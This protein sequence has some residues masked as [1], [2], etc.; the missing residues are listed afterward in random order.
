MCKLYVFNLS[1]QCL[2]LHLLLL[3]CALIVFKLL[4]V[5]THFILDFIEF[6]H[7]T[8]DF[9]G[10]ILHVLARLHELG[11]FRFRLLERLGDAAVYG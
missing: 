1:F 9:L 7:K 10:Q 11:L 2:Y 8:V 5:F 3:Y 6:L 4:A